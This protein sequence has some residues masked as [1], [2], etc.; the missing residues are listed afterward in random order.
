MRSKENVKMKVMIKETGKLEELNLVDD[1]T[2]VD[3]AIDVIGNHGG[4]DGQFV[5]DDDAGIY[6]CS[7]DTFDWWSRVLH[8]QQEL[9]DR[10]AE[11]RKEH[12]AERV[13]EVLEAVGDYDLEDMAAEVNAALDEAF[14]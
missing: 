6:H 2:G 4:L 3:S 7:Q 13:Q 5:Y 8:E 1:A 9:E 11:L 14:A 12:G 10:L